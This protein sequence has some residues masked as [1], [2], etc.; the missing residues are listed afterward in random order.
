MEMKVI[1]FSM[2]AVLAILFVAAHFLAPKEKEKMKLESKYSELL[3]SLVDKNSNENEE[4]KSLGLKLGKSPEQIEK[5]INVIL[6]SK[7]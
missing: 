4:V 6:S 3:L 1:A 2:M 7:N 5:D